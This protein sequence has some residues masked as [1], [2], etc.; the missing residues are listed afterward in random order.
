M[1][2]S[3]YEDLFISEAEEYIDKISNSI[4]LLEKNKSDT[5]AINEI[6]RAM[7]TIKGMAASMGYINISQIAH[8]LEDVMDLIR[9]GKIELYT[10][11][12]DILLKGNDIIDSLVHKNPVNEDIIRS[13]KA[14]LN[15]L[16]KTP[17]GISEKSGKQNS[18]DSGIQV[19]FVDDV[20]LKSARAFVVIKIVQDA[21]IYQN[22]NPSYDDIMK[23]NFD[24][25]FIIKVNNIE[26][27]KELIEQIKS[28]P[29][30]KN[31]FFKE[32]EEKTQESKKLEISNVDDLTSK[33]VSIKKDIKVAL[34]RLDALQ[35]YASE[36]V[37]ARGRLQQLAYKIQNEDLINALQNTS[38]IITNI[39]DEVMK[40]RMVPV[41]QVFDRY[42]RY[43][44]DLS[45]KLNKK[46][47]FEIKGRNIELDRSLLNALADPLLHLLRNSL[48]HGVEAPEERK[49]KGKNETGK[50]ILEAKR[51]KNAVVIIVKDD[52]KG[53]SSE[54]ILEKAIEKGL[55]S[56]EQTKTLTKQ[57][58]YHIITRNGFSTKEEVSDVSGRGVGV[59]AV[60]SVLK[61]IG[62]SLEI[63]SEEGKGT[64]FILKVPLTL[65]IIKSLIIRVSDETYIVP[66]TH[67]S[68]TI[69]I[70]KEQIQS[71]MGK[72]VFLLREK[73]IPIIRLSR[74]FNINTQEEREKYSLVIVDVDD[75]QFGILID[76]FIEQTEVVVKSL[77]GLLSG[78]QGIAGVTILNNGVPS[79]IIDVPGIF[80]MA[81]VG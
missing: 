31:A 51:L 44:R 43:V 57:D 40:I 27:A 64:S 11:L 59:D 13:F 19:E 41:G 28:I 65:A 10:E 3:K 30:V 39:Q 1:D 74:V 34:D 47:D 53:L 68:E 12:I 50:I 21:G 55:V 38:K 49:S 2:T 54:K 81:K 58:I 77:K 37:I 24:K 9:T 63:Q 5:E 33:Q 29:E 48:D 69:D 60:Q 70:N 56:K 14:V 61:K 17:S 42:P 8:A 32:K 6:F 52:G 75:N 36:L 67:I 20:V 79:F 26:K 16:K 62:G 78:I 23:E 76:E 80:E 71:I 73:V 18:E 35:N 72:E 22:T 7:H 45:K 25:S 15:S 46:V 66:L 4:L